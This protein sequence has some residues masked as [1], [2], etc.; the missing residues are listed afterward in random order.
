MTTEDLEEWAADF[1]TFHTRFAPF[2]GRKEPREAARRYLRGLLTPLPRKNCWQLAEALGEPDPQAFQR[3]LYQVAWDADV[4]QEELQQFVVEAFGHPEA[5]AV[6]DESSFV[7]KGTH[8][9]GVKR[10]WCGTLGKKENCQVGVFLAYVSPSGYA[11]LD[12]RLYLPEEWSQDA[13]R[14]EAAQVPPETAFH[15][16]GELGQAMLEAA[17][18]RQVPMRWVTG[19]EAYGDM[20]YLRERIAAEGLLYVLAISCNT[21]VWTEMPGTESP[22]H[23][24]FGRPRKHARL[25]P[26]APPSQPVVTVVAAWP[27]TQWQRLAIA[28]GEKGPRRYDWA[29]TRIVI[30]KDKLP[31]DEL[32]L[33]ARRS[34]EKPAEVAYYLSNAAPNTPLLTLAQVAGARWRIEQGFE[35]AKGEAGLDEYEVRSWPSWHRHITL[36]LMA[37]SWLTWIRGKERQRERKKKSSPASARRGAHA[38]GPAGGVN[39]GRSAAVIGNCFTVAA[40]EPSFP[41][42]L[43]TVATV[44]APAGSLPTLPA[45]WGRVSGAN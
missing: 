9:V 23:N 43:V 15:T 28:A 4:V 34:V 2:F 25:V 7:K 29:A 30:R 8:S 1:A 33:L 42:G 22:E 24:T 35:E 40:A 3:L 14:R 38:T 10:Q 11:F 6:L 26:E 27:E 12:R 32:W 13:A 16:K 18:Q 20:P 5:I 17:W 21:H 37:H 41:A 36:S 31:G 19:D 44:E 39:G 45:A